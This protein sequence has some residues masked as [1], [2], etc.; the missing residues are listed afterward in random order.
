MSTSIGTIR[1]RLF[2][3]EFWHTYVT[4]NKNHAVIHHKRLLQQTG[5]LGST[6]SR[7]PLTGEI[8]VG[9]GGPFMLL[10]HSTVNASSTTRPSSARTCLSLSF[11]TGHVTACSAKETHIPHRLSMAKN[12]RGLPFVRSFSC[13]GSWLLTTAQYLW[14]QPV[15]VEFLTPLLSASAMT[16]LKIALHR[17]HRCLIPPA[18][19]NC[20]TGSSPSGRATAVFL[21]CCFLH[22]S[23]HLAFIRA[24]GQRPSPPGGLLSTSHRAWPRQNR[25][26]QQPAQ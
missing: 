24:M 7:G 25:W 6:I 21:S 9:I 19:T 12:D 16:H 3:N 23:P 8:D 18:L 5:S 20:V 1:I 17:D 22:L 2:K 14:S 13:F 26:L 10:V 15:V 11:G 4:T